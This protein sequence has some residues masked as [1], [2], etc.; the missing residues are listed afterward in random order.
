MADPDHLPVGYARAAAQGMYGPCTWA[1]IFYFGVGPG[2][3]STPA[4]TMADIGQAVAALYDGLDLG[5]FSAD[6]ALQTVKVF[7]QDAEGSIQK[8]TVADAK[9]GTGSTDEAPAQVCY[10]LNWTGT[11]ARKGGKPRNYLCGVPG[12]RM[13][14]SAN[15]NSSTLAEMNLALATWLIDL[16]DTTKWTNGTALQLVE[17][18][19][20]EAKAKRALPVPYAI[21]TGHVSPV[22]ATQRRRVDRLR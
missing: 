3:G 2:D 11:D 5:N 20:Y 16:P 14:D 4:Q 13:A 8:A 1:N 22:V 19:F 7:W 10:L 17:M 15:I 6:W 9:A 12:D 21:N 18:S